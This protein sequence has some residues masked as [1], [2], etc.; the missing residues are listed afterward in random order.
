MPF[1][2]NYWKPLGLCTKSLVIGVF[3]IGMW[4][5]PRCKAMWEATWEVAV[6]L[7]WDSGQVRFLSFFEWSLS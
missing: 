7:Q 4:K 6:C 5:F 3:K 2:N 1:S